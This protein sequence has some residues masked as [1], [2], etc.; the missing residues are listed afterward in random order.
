[1]LCCCGVSAAVSLRGLPSFCVWC[2]QQEMI[3]YAIAQ[4]G[5]ARAGLF[6]LCVGAA[7]HFLSGSAKRAP[8]WMQ[9]LG[10]EW[11]HRLASE[12]ARMWKR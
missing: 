9:G 8:K 7:L 4:Y 6:G 11:L 2:A 10:L 12:P 3:A 1:M 5:D